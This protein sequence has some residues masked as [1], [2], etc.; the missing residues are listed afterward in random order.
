MKHI[1]YLTTNLVNNKIYIGVHKT[2]TPDKFD[3]YLGN[4]LWVNDMYLLNHPKE[5]FHYAVKKYGI[6]NFKRKTIKV[7]DNREDALDLER[8]LVNEEF[9]KRSDTYNIT[10]GGGDPP[11][12]NK[13]IY[14][15]SLTGEFIKEWNSIREA[16]IFYKVSDSSIGKA[17]LEGTPS[18]KYLWSDVKEFNILNFHI[19]ENKKTTYLYSN[20]GKFIKEFNSITECAN[21]IEKTPSRVQHCIKDKTCIN[22]QWYVSNI[23]YEEFLIPKKE[24]HR[25]K[26]IYQYD[27]EGNFI[28]EFPNQKTI[29]EYLGLKSCNVGNAIKQ[30]HSY[31]GFQW[32]FTKVPFMKK[33]ESKSGRIRK[34]GRYSK[35]G[36]LLETFNSVNETKRVWGSSA[37][38]CLRG[39]H[40]TCRGF[41]FK[42]IE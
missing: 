30:G 6:K 25:D 31:H 32:S 3:G 35:D 17:I 9:I 28:K 5:P 23:F 15:Y 12:Y 34:V 21:F 18:L 11:S 24:S 20:E 40:K 42:Y 33:L 4:G 16:A 26:P 1:V 41:I 7:F 2:N 10:I 36:E 14:Q 8:Q 27:L 13:T 37:V 39:S 19:N 38:G 22:K 29:A